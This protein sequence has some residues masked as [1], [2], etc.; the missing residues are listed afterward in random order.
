MTV[1]SAALVFAVIMSLVCAV[2]AAAAWRASSKAAKRLP[3][4]S[5]RVELDE[6]H[7]AIGKHSKLIRAQHARWVSLVRHH[8]E[9]EATDTDGEPPR[10][11][12]AA[13]K[14][15]LRRKVGLVAGRAVKHT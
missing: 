6:I 4:T 13:L 11:N 14:E 10:D 12:P 1:Q 8:E 7:D 2:F 5:L 15:Y 3:M 9:N